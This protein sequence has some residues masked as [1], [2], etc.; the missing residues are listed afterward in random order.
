MHGAHCELPTAATISGGDPAD[1][2]W[3]TF[4]FNGQL[5]SRLLIEVNA[6][7]FGGP[8]A[9]VADPEPWCS[10]AHCATGGEPISLG[11]RTFLFGDGRWFGRPSDPLRPN[12]MADAR[13]MESADIDRSI[14]LA[15]EAARRG[16]ITV[17]EIQLANGDGGLDAIVANHAVGGRSVRIRLGPA[18]GDFPTFAL[19][20][21]A[22][23]DGWE[24]GHEVVRLRLQSTA[25]LLNTPLQPRRYGGT[26]GLDGDAVNKDRGIP[27]CWGECFNIS[28]V[29][30]NRDQWIYQVH[31]AP[32]YA[33]DAVK[34]RGLP[35][36]FVADAA[37][38]TDLRLLDVPGG[39]YATCL[40]LGLIKIGHGVAG[41]AGAVT[42][43][44]RGDAT[45]GGYADTTGEILIRIALGRARLDGG[46]IDRATFTALPKGRI[47]YYEDGSSD[48]TV[49]SVFDDLLRA[50]IGYYGTTRGAA[51]TAN[52]PIPPTELSARRLDFDRHTILDIEPIEI[53]HQPRWAQA[54]TY[55]RN[56]TPT[57]LDQLSE[58]LDSDTRERLS[59]PYYAVRRVAGE[60][61]LRNRSAIEGSLIETYFADLAAAEGVCE[62][63]MDMFRET[64]RRF[65][66]TVPRI[67]YIVDLGQT[68]RITY[69]R[70]GF[71]GGR[72]M[73]VVGIRDAGA[74]GVNELTV[75]G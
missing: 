55:A 29:L 28:P 14:P 15:P 11:Q 1:D 47:G 64:R 18:D 61:Q 57:P 75:W 38:Y 71:Q 16:E 27:S 25:A 34:E 20:Q 33:V 51:L 39:S 43:D 52:T 32:I 41:P 7:E 56:W 70:F 42:A 48:V 46:L 68:V 23:A 67:G 10:Y 19:I 45:S 69:P 74:R 24:A 49:A 66:V 6:A 37:S 5:R 9:V 44:V 13:I 65:R 4:L 40:A 22:I 54:A 8:L 63:A 30:I 73:L 59:F 17:G 36:D 2:A 21:E 3:R 60:V 31:D 12:A 58:A 53:D 50:V 62:R 35:F 72:N 26:G